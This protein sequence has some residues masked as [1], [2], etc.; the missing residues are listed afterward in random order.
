MA[1]PR[2]EAPD[3][4]VAQ[5]GVFVRDDDVARHGQLEPTGHRE[6][7]H[8][9]DDHLSGGFQRFTDLLQPV[10]KGLVRGRVSQHAARQ[11]LQIGARAKGTTG[12]PDHDDADVAPLP[13]AFAHRRDQA[14]KGRSIQRVEPFRTVEHKRTDARMGVVDQQVGRGAC[15]GSDV[16][17]PGC[18]SER[19]S[20]PVA[21]NCGHRCLT[22]T[23]WLAYA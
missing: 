19:A 9:G 5:F 4:F 11:P 21:W 16:P 8:A 7:L 14:L 22:T 18:G 3:V 15:Q 23:R 1:A 2:S 17:G 20:E 6:P 12:R 10:L 13:G